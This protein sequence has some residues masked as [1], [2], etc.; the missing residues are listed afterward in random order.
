[1]ALVSRHCPEVF[2][3]T[4]QVGRRPSAASASSAVCLFQAEAGRESGKPLEP[5]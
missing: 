1:M 4:G 2:P 5:V 3:G